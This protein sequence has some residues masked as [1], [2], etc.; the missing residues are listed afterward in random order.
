MVIGSS[1]H[2]ET[3]S[4]RCS[5]SG[6]STKFHTCESS[7]SSGSAWK[8]W[9]ASSASSTA[10]ASGCHTGDLERDLGCFC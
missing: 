7:S 9:S 10:S 3:C 5:R 2:T 6:S 1:E 8:P 4:V